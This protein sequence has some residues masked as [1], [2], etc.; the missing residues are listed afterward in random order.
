MRWIL[1]AILA[2]IISSLVLRFSRLAAALIV[3]IVFVIGGFAWY[4]Q[5]QLEASKERIPHDQIELVDFKLANPSLNTHAVVGR[6]R[7][8]SK[9][10]TVEEIGLKILIDDCY[11][12]HCDTVDQTQVIFSEPIPPG[13]A[14]DVH[15][16]IVLDALFKPKGRLVPH[17]RIAYV[18]AD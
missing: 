18:K 4:Q 2:L 10:Y 5:H 7:N 17:F 9:Q 15:T 1:L 3:G 8:H 12:G 14:R 6:I 16:R 13:Q 11:S